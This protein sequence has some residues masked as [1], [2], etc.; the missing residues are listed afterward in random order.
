MR[1]ADGCLSSLQKKKTHKAQGLIT[2]PQ[3][4]AWKYAFQ[5]TSDHTIRR[6][7]NRNATKDLN[8]VG[9]SWQRYILL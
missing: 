4:T 8:N 3:Y 9:F 5:Q 6:K 7:K 1:G 2:I